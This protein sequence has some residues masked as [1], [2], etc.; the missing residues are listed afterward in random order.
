MSVLGLWTRSTRKSEPE[1]N[2][3][4]AVNDPGTFS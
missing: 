1:A 3:N 2:R 4:S